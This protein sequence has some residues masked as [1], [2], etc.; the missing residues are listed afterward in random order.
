MKHTTLINPLAYVLLGLNV[1]AIGMLGNALFG[2]PNYAFFSQLKLV[3]LIACIGSAVYLLRRDGWRCLILLPLVLTGS[4]HF[5]GKNSRM[6][7]I[8]WNWTAIALLSAA[9][10]MILGEE[11]SRH[12][13]VILE[14]RKETHGHD[15]FGDN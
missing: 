14:S 12:R 9:I 6:G 4:I 10:V 15:N 1:A 8:P 13:A 11:K 7:W 3:V 2:R 5:Y